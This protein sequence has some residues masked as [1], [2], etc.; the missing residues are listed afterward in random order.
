M[1]L[2]FS[3]KTF[4]ISYDVGSL[5]CIEK[6]LVTIVTLGFFSQIKSIWFS[7]VTQCMALINSKCLTFPTWA[8]LFQIYM[9]NLI[10][11][12]Q[13]L[14]IILTHLALLDSFT[15]SRTTESCQGAKARQGHTKLSQEVKGKLNTNFMQII[16]VCTIP[17]MAMYSHWLG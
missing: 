10:L 6:K 8:D 17:V 11:Q 14:P 12:N 2:V 16:F 13:Q 5:H 7:A 1:K 4:I 3:N 15:E 9:L